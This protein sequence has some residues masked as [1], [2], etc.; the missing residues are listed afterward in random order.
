MSTL[1]IGKISEESRKSICTLQKS[2]NSGTK[3]KRLASIKTP[4]ARDSNVFLAMG[5]MRVST[6]LIILKHNFALSQ[7]EKTVISSTVPRYIF[8]VN[9]NQTFLQIA[10]ERFPGVVLSLFLQLTMARGE[11]LVKGQV[12]K[13]HKLFG[14]IDYHTQKLT[15]RTWQQARRVLV[16]VR[17][18][19]WDLNHLYLPQVHRH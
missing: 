19:L 1:T 18:S 4:A 2:A 11:A 15:K 7:S 3:Q 17:C 10:S 12:R 9:N 16:T 8:P 6:I 14:P 13:R 5:G